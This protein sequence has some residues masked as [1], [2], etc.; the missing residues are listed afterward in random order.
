M[1]IHHN[2]L[3]LFVVST[4]LCWT[5]PLINMCT[6]ILRVYAAVVLLSVA[7]LAATGLRQD[8]FWKIGM[9]QNSMI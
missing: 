6:D 5:V 8:V 7:D 4:A 9:S 2:C 3:S 1:H